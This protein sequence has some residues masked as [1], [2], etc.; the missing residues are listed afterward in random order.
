MRKLYGDIHFSEETYKI[1]RYSDV[2]IPRGTRITFWLEFEHI[3]FRNKVYLHNILNEL[4]E[5]KLLHTLEKRKI[6]MFF[7]VNP[8]SS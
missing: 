8:L 5:K 4:E 3:R 6:I 7:K 2:L 1:S